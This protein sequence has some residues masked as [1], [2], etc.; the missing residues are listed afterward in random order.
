MY[1]K[2]QITKT[3][4][5][6]FQNMNC[7]PW[8]KKILVLIH[9]K[10]CLPR[11]LCQILPQSTETH[12][13]QNPHNVFNRFSY[14]VTPHSTTGHHKYWTFQTIWQV[15]SIKYI[16]KFHT[17]HNALWV[18]HATHQK[19]ESLRATSLSKLDNMVNNNSIFNTF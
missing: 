15:K 3:L 18:K 12:L 7:F 19:A 16:I 17:D 13:Q 1:S 6:C 11:H 14:S 9:L 8:I 5:N 10:Y 4:E 2:Y